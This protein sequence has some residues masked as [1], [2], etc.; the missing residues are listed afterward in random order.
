MRRVILIALVGLVSC[1]KKETAG[2]VY[3]SPT[4]QFAIEVQIGDKEDSKNKYEIFLRL[5]D[6]DGD[7]LDITRTKASAVMNYAVFW[8]ND[9]T[10]VL[11]S[12]DIGVYAWRVTTDEK[13]IPSS[14]D[15][16]LEKKATEIFNKKMGR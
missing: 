8:H 2:E 15:Y 13:I 1:N 16:K 11:Y 6:E 7:E 12:S 4:G 10:V 9:K 5:L 14:V 3:Y